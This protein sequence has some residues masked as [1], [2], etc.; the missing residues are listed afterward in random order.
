[1]HNSIPIFTFMGNHFLKIEAK[2]SF[3]V[4]CQAIDIIIPHIQRACLEKEKENKGKQNLL[5]ETSLSIINTFV[6]ASSDMPPHRFK[7]F[8]SQLVRNL[9]STAFQIS[10][11]VQHTDIDKEKSENITTPNNAMST[12]EIEKLKKVSCTTKVQRENV[13]INIKICEMQIKIR[14][15]HK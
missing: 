1:M 13:N 14:D 4:A 11:A 15:Q 12:E 5:R 9:S 7:T 8:M 2:S 6:D 10:P 3:D